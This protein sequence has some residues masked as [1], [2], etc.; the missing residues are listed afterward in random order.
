MKEL[1]QRCAFALLFP[2]AAAVMVPALLRAAEPPLIEVH[3][4]PT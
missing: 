3:Y 4:N 2:V 1:L